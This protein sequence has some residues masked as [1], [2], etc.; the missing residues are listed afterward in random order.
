MNTGSTSVNVTTKETTAI[1]RLDNKAEGICV[2]LERAR[3][4]LQELA[5]RLDGSQPAPSS[6][7]EKPDY[8]G[9]LGE[10]E[11]HIGICESLAVR[12]NELVDLLNRL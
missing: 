1:K 9:E 4:H 12:I 2:G 5:Q 10:L 8:P 11:G 6:D 3:A 7:S